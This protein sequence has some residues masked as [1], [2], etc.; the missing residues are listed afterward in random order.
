[1]QNT[2]SVCLCRSVIYD[3]SYKHNSKLL[4]IQLNIWKIWVTEGDN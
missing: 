1:M 2:E 3:G 4:S